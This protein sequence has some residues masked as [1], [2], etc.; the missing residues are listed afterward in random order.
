MQDEIIR[1]NTDPF[2]KLALG[3]SLPWFEIV[4]K[5]WGGVRKILRGLSNEGMY[6]VL[7]FESTLELL[8][9]RGERAVYRKREKVKY[10]QDYII[11]Y[12]D[13]AWGDGDILLNYRCK[14]G[15]AVD[16]YT[17]GRTAHILISLHDVKYRGDIDEFKIE[18]GIQKGFLRNQE[19]WETEI[20]HRTKHLKTQLI[21]PKTRPPQR[22][23][24]NENLHR[25]S[26]P[27]DRESISQLPD[28][29]WLA[30]WETD[31]PK[32]HECYTL[33]WEW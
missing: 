28:G 16:R 17:P 9:R 5:L 10:L 15:V 8:D 20:S 23:S 6:E 14:P 11:A 3:L 13:Q 12:Q 29:R 7:D 27:L 32:L 19:L 18:W 30:S 33:C 31:H 22:V 1:T 25:R 26:Y 4:G 24:I 2:T 21:F